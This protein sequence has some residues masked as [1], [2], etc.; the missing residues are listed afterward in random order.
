VLVANNVITHDARLRF[1]ID[2]ILKEWN[3]GMNVG[4]LQCSAAIL[5]YF[6][7]VHTA[8]VYIVQHYIPP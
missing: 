8:R 5:S 3:V 1:A 2:S 4:R 7:V 6:T